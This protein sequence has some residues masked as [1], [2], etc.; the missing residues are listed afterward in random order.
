MRALNLGIAEKH[1]LHHFQKRH[2]LLR[3]MR[4]THK[5]SLFPLPAL[6]DFSYLCYKLLTHLFQH[7][8]SACPKWYLGCYPDRLRLLWE[9]HFNPL[10]NLC[11]VAPIWIPESV[12]GEAAPASQVSADFSGLLWSNPPRFQ[13]SVPLNAGSTSIHSHLWNKYLFNTYYMLALVII[14]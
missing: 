10:H 1:E 2:V 6:L 9:S 3:R 8:V 11:F 5:N 4:M 7:S 14:R 12:T 13:G